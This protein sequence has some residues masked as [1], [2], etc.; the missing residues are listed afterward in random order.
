MELRGSPPKTLN[1]TFD[2][3]SKMEDG[4]TPF[5]VADASVMSTFKCRIEPV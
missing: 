4:T 3:N 1:T 2:N 5:S